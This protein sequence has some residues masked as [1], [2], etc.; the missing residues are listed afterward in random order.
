MRKMSSSWDEEA[1]SAALHALEVLDTPPEQ[2]FDELARIAG[3]ICDAPIAVVNF[4]DTH[5]QFF[6]AE[7]GLGVRST[8]L[9]TAFCTHALLAE[10]VLIINDATKDPRVQ[11]NPLVTSADTHLRAYAGALLKTDYGI[12]VGTICVLDTKPRAFSDHQIKM[13][14]FLA[15]QVMT[16]LELRQTISQQKELLSRVRSAEQGRFNF[17]RVVR[18]A[19][20]FIGIADPFGRVTF[21]NEAAKQLL[22]L[23]PARFPKQ[24]SDYIFP[25]DRELFYQNVVPLLRSGESFEG[26]LRFLDQISLLAIPVHY[27]VFPIHENNTLL[28]FGVV[29]RDVSAQKADQE[30]RIKVVEEAAHRIKNILSIVQVI[31][32]QTLRNSATME[33]GRDKVSERLAALARAQDALSAADQPIADIRHIVGEALSPHNSGNGR[34]R[35]EGPS[36]LLQGPQAFGLTLALHELATNATKYGALSNEAGIVTVRWEH[37]DTG[38]RFTWTETDGPPV[39]PPKTT[40]FGSKLVRS[41]VAPYFSGEA[42]LHYDA[43][44]LRFSLSGGRL[45]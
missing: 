4:V 37:D 14:Q 22:C 5:R 29:A 10:D 18:Q 11:D 39:L 26:E 43:A 1:R 13:L 12:P 16:Q 24:V 23:D 38:F 28:G 21:L 15:R 17:E 42:E 19:S 9:E 36:L 25:D 44:G 30:R 6:K 33:E 7:V 35:F 27:T 45:T 2:E 34:L 31:V 8:P 3:E 40:G 41:M 32:G 20:D